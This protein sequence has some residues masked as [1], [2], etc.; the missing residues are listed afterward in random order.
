MLIAFV[1]FM[2]CPIIRRLLENSS[3][4]ITLV[5]IPLHTDQMLGNPCQ[6][7]GKMVGLMDEALV[8]REE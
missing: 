4:T 5:V 1:I 6:L 3:I 2:S 8:L 7:F